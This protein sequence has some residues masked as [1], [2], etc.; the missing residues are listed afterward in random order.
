[1]EKSPNRLRMGSIRSMNIL[2]VV[3]HPDDPEFFCG[4]TI[5][6]WTSEGHAVSYLIVTDGAKGNDDPSID[7]P[8]LIALRQTEQRAAGAEIGVTDIRFLTYGDG[9]LANTLALQ[10]D[11]VRHVRDVKPEI[12]VTT[13]PRTLHYGA[14][15][16][17]HNDHRL[18]GMAVCD[19]I[20]PASNNRMYFPELLAE[21]F[22]MF[23]PRELW[24]AAPDVP[25]QLIDVSAQF[26]A[27]V[28]AI[29]AHTSQVKQ[30]AQVNIRI[31]QGLTRY[32]ADGSPWLAEAFR[33][34][35]L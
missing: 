1:M 3:A 4:G 12:V 7:G 31:R 28:A 27:K 5:A 19:A 23:G 29:R 16:V 8:T 22:E 17:N 21:G 33:R 26:E 34:V 9:E 32:H 15:R 24:F 30:P 10:R 13:D 2:V 25:N 14:T 20:F 18:I 11:I 35:M 6:R